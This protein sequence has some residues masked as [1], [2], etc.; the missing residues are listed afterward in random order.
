MA[1]APSYDRPPIPSKKRLSPSPEVPLTAIFDS[2]A[3][4]TVGACSSSIPSVSRGGAGLSPFVG[5][6]HSEAGAA[7]DAAAGSAEPP[8]TFDLHRAQQWTAALTHWCDSQPDLVPFSGN[9]LVHRA[10]IME[11]PA[12]PVA[13]LS[14]M[15]VDLLCWC[16]P[17]M[18]VWAAHARA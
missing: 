2:D 15:P 18:P 6:R 8:E 3:S 14:G 16:A 5:E 1:R 17:R 11:L 9:C 10:E 13:R 7:P 12:A 4:V